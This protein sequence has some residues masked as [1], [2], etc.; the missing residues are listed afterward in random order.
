V[1]Y[2]GEY[3]DQMPVTIA[4]MGQVDEDTLDEGVWEQLRAAF[5]E[6]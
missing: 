4:L 2:C 6:S 1:P 3:L 5:R